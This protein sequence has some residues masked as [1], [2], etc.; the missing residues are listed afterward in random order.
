MSDGVDALMK[1]VQP[2]LAEAMLNRPNAYPAEL[3][4]PPR[5]HAVLKGRERSNARIDWA[6]FALHMNA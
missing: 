5:H 2:A 3:E 6:V 1:Q 4:L